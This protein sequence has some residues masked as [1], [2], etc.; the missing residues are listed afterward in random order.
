[1]EGKFK[2]H[3]LD[4]YVNAMQVELIR[5]LSANNPEKAAREYFMTLERLENLN[6]SFMKDNWTPE[7]VRLD[8][9]NYARVKYGIDLSDYR[10]TNFP[11]LKVCEPSLRHS[12]MYFIDDS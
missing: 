9:Q 12:P 5:R 10:S 1:M 11:N 8:I 4:A 7:D 3:T 6:G 2:Y